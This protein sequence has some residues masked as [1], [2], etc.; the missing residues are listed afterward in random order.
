MFARSIFARY[1]RLLAGAGIAFLAFSLGGCNEIAAQKADPGRPVLVATVHYQPESPARSF[2]GT[3]RPRTETEMG[4]R[5]SGKVASRMVEVGPKADI[6]R[7]AVTQRR[8]RI[9]IANADAARLE[10]ARRLS[11]EQSGVVSAEVEGDALEVI[12]EEGFAN[13]GLLRHLLQVA[14]SSMAEMNSWSAN[15][16]P[17]GL[18]V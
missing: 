15:P 16:E 8:L 9:E 1:Y 5:V 14:L 12:V 3:I 17:S 4:F 2:V 7:G 11:A 13:H 10:A 18:K 6:L